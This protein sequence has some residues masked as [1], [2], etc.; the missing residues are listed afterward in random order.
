MLTDPLATLA[1]A[2][3]SATPNSTVAAPTANGVKMEAVITKPVSI[4]SFMCIL[5][6]TV[7]N[8]MNTFP[9]LCFYYS[10]LSGHF[11]FTHTPEQNIKFSYRKYVI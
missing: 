9:L 7:Q 8:E 1:S 2:A 5:H 6:S 10:L 3:I 4:T 11:L